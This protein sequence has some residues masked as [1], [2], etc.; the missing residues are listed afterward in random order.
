ME[1][2][3]EEFGVGCAEF[4]MPMRQP[5]GGSEQGVEI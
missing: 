1:G 3:D 4:E 2:G 5:G